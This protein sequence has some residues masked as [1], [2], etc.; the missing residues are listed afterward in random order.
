MK[1]FQKTLSTTLLTL[2][3][4][5]TAFAGDITGKAGDITGKAGDITDRKVLSL[6]NRRL[7]V[8]DDSGQQPT[9]F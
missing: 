9:I 4:S 3:I 2:V 8:D 7:R 6:E 5:V 1:L